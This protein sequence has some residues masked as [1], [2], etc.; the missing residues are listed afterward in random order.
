MMLIISGGSMVSYKSGQI[1]LPCAIAVMVNYINVNFCMS[2]TI[3]FRKE[4]QCHFLGKQ[5]NQTLQF[6]PQRLPSTKRF[7]LIV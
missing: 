7:G 2:G 3:C 5:E 4:L 6:E 1:G